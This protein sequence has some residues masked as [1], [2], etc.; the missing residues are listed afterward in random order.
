[1]YSR[2]LHHGSPPNHSRRRNIVYEIKLKMKE[3]VLSAFRGDSILSNERLLLT[4]EEARIILILFS[5]SS[6]IIG[7]MRKKFVPHSIRE[8]LR[9]VLQVMKNIFM[10]NTRIIH[11]L[12]RHLDM[13]FFTTVFQTKNRGKFDL[14]MEKHSRNIKRQQRGY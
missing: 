2:I 11:F 7:S 8:S 10:E 14:I 12:R 13:R 3:A 6:I 5:S 1:M 4:H 9:V